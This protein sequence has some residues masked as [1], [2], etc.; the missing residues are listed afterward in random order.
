[1]CVRGASSLHHPKFQFPSERMLMG[2]Q[3]LSGSISSSWRSAV[4]K[5][6]S[7]SS[8]PPMIPRRYADFVTDARRDMAPQ[9]A[10]IIPP[11]CGHSALGS[12]SSKR[13]VGCSVVAG[14]H[15]VGLT[16]LPPLRLTGLQTIAYRL[17]QLITLQILQFTDLT[18]YIVSH[19]ALTLTLT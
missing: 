13:R 11:S 18:H 9:A 14:T 16:T 8:R 17:L 10:T 12:T 4:S 2:R 3:R 5:T 1:M 15:S 19:L 7:T 6:L